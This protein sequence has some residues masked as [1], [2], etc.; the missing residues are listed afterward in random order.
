MK[1]SLPV[2]GWVTGY[3]LVFTVICQLESPLW[4]RAGMFTL[5]PFLVIYMVWRV[6]HDRTV[7]VPDLAPDDE[8]G[9]TDYKPRK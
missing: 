7:V 1:S 8:F 3:L 9:Y 6:L 5:S 4:L 2:V